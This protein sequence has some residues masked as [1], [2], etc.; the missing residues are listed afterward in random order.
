MPNALSILKQHWNHDAF[1]TPQDQ[2]IDAVLAQKDCLALLPTG[3]GKSICFQ[4]P[5]LLQDGLCLVISPLIALMKDQVENLQK[6]NIKALALTGGLSTN[7]LIDLLD[8]CQFGNYKFLYLSPERL[9]TAWIV[10]RLEKLP[11]SLIAI[12]EAHCISQWGHDF[13]PTYLKIGLLR[14]SF[15]KTP[16]IALTAS[17]T[18]RVQN[19][20]IQLLGL[21]DPAIFKQSFV[22][23][24]LS[25][26]VEHTAD[27]LYFL[28]HYFK[29]F[30]QPA[31]IYVR[32]RKSCYDYVAQLNALGFLATLY[33]GGLTTKEKEKNRHDWMQS[34]AQ[35]MVAT[36]AFGMGIDRA[37]VKSVV[38]VQLPDSLENYY[39]EAGRAGRDGSPAQAILL[40]GPS[41]CL[42]AENQFIA[43]LPDKAF[44]SL[45]YKKLCAYFQIAYGE[46]LHEQFRLN[47]Q[48]F[49]LKYDLP[50]VKT[51]SCL[52]FLDRQGVV[53]LSTEFSQKVQLQFTIPSK[54][55]LRYCS[56][57][58][59]DEA[60]V[61][62]LMRLYP[63]IY[64][65]LVPLNIP[66]IAQKSATN[67]EAVVKVLEKLLQK[68]MVVYQAHKNDTAILFMEIRDDDYTI[69]RIAKFLT[70]QNELKSQQLIAVLKYAAQNNCCCSQFLADYFGDSQTDACGHCSVCSASSSKAT[71]PKEVLEIILAEL[72]A[73]P[74]SSREL[75]T[76]LAI[77]ESSLIFALQSLLENKQIKLEATN[78]YTLY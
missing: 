39:Q 53:Q 71:N 34:K 46:G 21:R 22:R 38:H 24:N 68:E 64:D 25:Y 69:N 31:I 56:L 63:G 16:M 6:R 45:V 70:T 1:R 44:L 60:I 47:L 49:C 62:T 41:D 30:P 59:K 61:S 15:P 42:Q 74:F 23:T 13:R 75:A 11:I 5:T 2:I 40:V 26:R 10:E 54:E 76:K 9:Q 58:P 55:V 4:V 29:Q 67:E 72:Q 18:A 37:D 28:E 7:D 52:Q 77:D 73:G 65:M 14:H 27:K 66:L 50:T 51:F 36:N 20:I 48:Q 78:R 32:N 57:H 33:H 3:G 12:D 35:I 8:N 43:Q 19:D 17:A